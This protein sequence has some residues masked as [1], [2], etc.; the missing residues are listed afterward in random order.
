MSEKNCDNS[1]DKKVEEEDKDSI[2]ERLKEAMNEV[3]ELGGWDAF[4]SGI[5]LIRLIRKSFRNLY[6]RSDPE[7]FRHKYPHFDDDKISN[8][9][10]KVTARNAAI[11]GAVVGATVST[12]DIVAILTGF[13]GGVGLP[14]NIAI[15]F[16]AVAGEAVLLT[17]MQLKLVANIAK[18]YGVPL[19]PDD[20]EDILTIIAFAVG[21][22][23]AESAGKA[24]MRIGGKLT[25]RLIKNTIKK[26]LLDSIK[27]VGEK[28]G[29]KILQRTIIKYAVPI[30]PMGIGG[31]WNY[32]STRAVG[33]IAG[34]HFIARAKEIKGD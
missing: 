16:A 28:V 19:D 11:L 24:G 8:K 5:W 32:F 2:R 20:P 21:G 10:T 17:R 31:S 34:N 18:L 13:E 29:I 26:E 14:A 15:A 3:E 6:E 27:K 30:A 12:D 7:Y 33:K 23:A 1:S 22:S 25:E 4:K 9:I